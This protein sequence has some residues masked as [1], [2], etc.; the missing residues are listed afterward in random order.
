MCWAT[1]SLHV[2][3]CLRQHMQAQCRQGFQLLSEGVLDDLA[4]HVRSVLEPITLRKYERNPAMIKLSYLIERVHPCSRCSHKENAHYIIYSPLDPVHPLHPCEFFLPFLRSPLVLSHG[5]SG[6][7][8]RRNAA[9]V[10]NS[11]L[12]R[13]RSKIATPPIQPVKPTLLPLWI[14]R[15]MVKGPPLPSLAGE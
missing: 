14:T 7:T 2:S 9:R 15:P 11:F 6:N 4:F 5:F 12:S 10:S 8:F 3:W 13:A 1:A